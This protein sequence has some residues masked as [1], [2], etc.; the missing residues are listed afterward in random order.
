MVAA[1]RAMILLI[2]LAVAPPLPPDVP[3]DAVRYSVLLSGNLAGHQAVWTTPDGQ[4]H[5]HY[6]YNDR[7]RGPVLRT[8]YTLDPSGLP[9][10]MDTAGV[11][12]LKG[13]VTETLAS[14]RGITRWSNN[15]EHGQKRAQMPVYFP[16]IHAPPYA[17]GMLA[18]FLSTA[19]EQRVALL[20]EGEARLRRMR[21]LTLEAKG[22][23]QKVTLF[24]ITG[25]SFSPELLWLDEK[26]ELFASG[27]RWSM[28]VREGW[29]GTQETLA[30]AQD[31]AENE[32]RSALAADLIQRPR[33]VLVKNVAVF[34]SMTGK[35]IA[36]QYVRIRGNKIE[37]VGPE[38]L[39]QIEGELELDGRGGTL[40]PGLW[41]M[42]AHIS[43][44]DGLLNIS[45]GVT[46]V[47][48]LANQT[49][50]LLAR[51]KRFDDGL[52]IGPRIIACGF[53]D[54]PGP[55]QGPTKVL[56]ATEAE[57]RAAVAKYAE[58]GFPQIKIYS[59]IK[60]ELVPHLI[61]EAHQRGMR[62]SGHIPATMFAD[63]FVKLGGD[64]IQHIN[65]VMLSFW[66]D[67]TQTAT[68]AR[69]VEPAKRAA[70]LDLKSKEV[71]QL[72]QLLV[73]RDVVVDPTL[74]IF[75]SM[76][77]AR[78][79]KVDPAFAAVNDRFPSQMRRGSLQGGLT[80]DAKSDAVYVKSFAKMVELVGALHKA[81]VRL[82][83]GTDTLAG[84]GLH[85]ELELYVK[86][87]IPPAD[88]LRIATLEAAKVMK[89]DGELGSIAVGKLADV[90]LVDGDP[91][92]DISVVRK[93]RL[94]IKDGA[95]F[96][97]AKIH[98]AIGVSPAKTR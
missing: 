63:E 11:D 56:V 2:S 37:S 67:V 69:F 45:A 23:K 77:V 6:Q 34:D 24:A 55:F 98:Q 1:M 58:L 85:R 25:F 53:I 32:H 20:P 61:D 9:V 75:E 8:V 17:L 94:V 64:E 60:P 35:R 41:D 40:I 74:V 15:A 62:V 27:G 30:Q 59:S 38:P 46:T 88:V 80:V 12:Y 44:D 36:K 4:R 39:T 21:E 7:G 22:Q 13:A 18:K 90:V 66:R 31:T 92:K 78:P 82:V 95:L 19:K 3:S 86:A 87:G 72:I 43:G 48:D 97:P 28:T 52:E 26:G 10:R 71:K 91:T 83:A 93:P 81:G 84:F 79:G 16:P 68:P 73:D 54:G 50:E 89:R 14:E 5:V 65:F 76:F 47:R 57:A 96:D 51:R 70:S 42:H 33:G 29:E 49:E